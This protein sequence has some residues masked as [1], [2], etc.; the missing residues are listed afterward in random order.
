MKSKL[1]CLPCTIRTARDIAER[2]TEDQD[3]RKE[4]IFRTMKWLEENSSNYSEKTPTVLHTKVCQIAKEVTGNQDPFSNVKKIS[5]DR[6]KE[7]L[8]AVK[9]IIQNQKE[10]L[11]TF[12]IALKASIY[13]NAI[14]FEVE[15]HEFDPEDIKPEMMKCMKG[16]LSI[17]DTE[18]LLKT[19][20]DSEKVLYLL[21]NAGEIVFDALL[22]DEIQKRFS[23]NITSVVKEEPVLND[24]TKE[25]ARDIGL[26]E[27]TEVITTGDDFVG[28]HPKTVSEEFLT[29]LESSDLVIAKGQGNYESVTEIPLNSPICYILKAKCKEIAEDLDVPIMGNVVKMVNPDR[30][31][32]P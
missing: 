14:D 27:N 12:K 6:A 11:E 13:G 17:D 19:L 21:D 24:A 9:E 29:R 10:P 1:R 31:S 7:A 32:Q 22:I 3:L 18:E 23:C 30:R 16:E 15:E 2:A 5:N 20:E 28:V 25:D 8:P 26:D 4:I